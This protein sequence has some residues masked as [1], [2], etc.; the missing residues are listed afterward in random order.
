MENLF[1]CC[2]FPGLTQTWFSQ[3]YRQRRDDSL[4]MDVMMS[5]SPF[6]T[7]ERSKIRSPVERRVMWMKVGGQAARHG[8]LQRPPELF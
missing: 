8:A 6:G 3:L 1:C 2:V 4:V 7:K 5:R